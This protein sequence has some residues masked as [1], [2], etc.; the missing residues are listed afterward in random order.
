MANS[1]LQL[2]SQDDWSIFLGSQGPT[3]SEIIKCLGLSH[4]NEGGVLKF[5][6]R[7]SRH[8]SKE[9][10]ELSQ[11]LPTDTDALLR[12]ALDPNALDEAL[13]TLLSSHGPAIWGE[14]ADRK[15]LLVTPSAS[16]MSYPKELFFEVP[17]DKS[18]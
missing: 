7:E 13:N 2:W 8:L 12:S 5:P 18:M 17:V 3:V 16:D 14:N 9:V 1:P 10:Q 11:N 6:K 15:R 4:T